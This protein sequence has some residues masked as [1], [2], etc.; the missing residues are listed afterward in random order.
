[1]ETINYKGFEIEIVPDESYESPQDWGDD[2]LFLVGFHRDFTVTTDDIKEPSNIDEYKN[3]YWILPLY[4]YIH[5]GVALSL[6][7][8]KYLFN[9]R[10]DSCQVGAV[11]AS[12]KEFKTIE[13][14][15]RVGKGLVDTWN[16]CLSGNVWGYNVDEIGAS[17]YGYYGDYEKSGLIEDAKS[18]IDF[19]LEK[20]YGKKN[21][22]LKDLIKNK[23][24]IEKREN[25][26]SNIR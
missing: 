5:S 22:K 11:L 18:E 15:Y 25:I 13:E 8:A 9:C 17:C 6:S 1:M 21:K 24:K 12:K 19:Y 20:L 14:A 2:S 26:L 16:D 10:W 7:D 4:A 23:V 3:A